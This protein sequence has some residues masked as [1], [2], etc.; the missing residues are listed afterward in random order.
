MIFTPK[1]LTG[2]SL[3][4]AYEQARNPDVTDMRVR[5]GVIEIFLADSDSE[6]GGSRWYLYKRR[7]TN[8]DQARKFVAEQLGEFIIVPTDLSSPKY[9]HRK[10]E[11]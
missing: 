4:W 5:E 2:K 1:E 7:L 11:E 10:H 3:D 9:A 8:E 6:Y